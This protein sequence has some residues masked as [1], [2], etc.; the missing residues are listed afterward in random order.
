MRIVN[1]SLKRRTDFGHSI[2]RNATFI[3]FFGHWS[4]KCCALTRKGKT[5]N[6]K[7]QQLCAAKSLLYLTSVNIKPYL[8]T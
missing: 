7:G 6:P 8:K 3:C 5:R 1:E 4:I 2:P